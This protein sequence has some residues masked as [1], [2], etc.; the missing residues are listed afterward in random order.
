MAITTSLGSKRKCG[1]IACFEAAC[2]E[3]PVNRLALL[4]LIPFVG[5]WG[6]LTKPS[7]D[8]LCGIYRGAIT[9]HP[10]DPVKA[11]LFV[12]AR[13]E[14]IY[15]KDR[16]KTAI[17]WDMEILTRWTE[18]EGTDAGERAEMLKGLARKVGQEKWTCP[19]AETYWKMQMAGGETDKNDEGVE[20]STTSFRTVAQ[21][22]LEKEDIQKTVRAHQAAIQ[23]C[24]VSA[25]RKRP[26]LAGKVIVRF[27]I[28]PEGA[29]LEAQ[30]TESI[31]EPS[32]D[33]CIVKQVKSWKFPKPKGG[34][35]F[36]TYPFVF[37]PDR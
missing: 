19:E 25:L 33:A 26:D 1:R 32:V 24:Y 36:V 9:K 15:N 31:G 20:T 17:S 13:R 3:D 18:I 4:L 16:A 23:K 6:P 11:K 7:L 8:R 28:S 5:A 12:Q 37:Q 29:V 30:A 22:S 34:K 27:A 35:V 2:L 21:G 10:S 14:A